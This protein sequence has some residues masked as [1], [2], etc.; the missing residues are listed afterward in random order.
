MD[1]N[2]LEKYCLANSTS[3]DEKEIRSI[4]KDEI[5]AY[6]DDIKTDAM[7]NL[8]VF[9]KGKE[10]AK[11][12]LMLSAHMDEVG[13]IVTHITED[14]FLKFAPVGGI[15]TM[16][17]PGLYVTVGKNN[18][19]GVV[20]LA[21]IHLQKAEEKQTPAQID[22]LCI[23]IGA[24]SKEDAKVAVSEGD[25]IYFKSIFECNSDTVK[26][27]AIDDRM[28]C[29]ILTELI[30]QELPY[31][32]HFC[33]LV[34]E[35][36]G[37]RGAHGAAFTVE[38]DCALVIDVTTAC[39]IPGVPKH[40]QITKLSAGATLPLMDSSMVYD[41]DFLSLAREIANRENMNIQ[42]KEATTGGT[43][44]GSIFLSRG[45]VKTG[46]VVGCARYIHSACSLANIKDMEAVFELTKAMINEICSKKWF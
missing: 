25:F 9:K 29:F 17:L 1:I 28:G 37:T 45:G 33:F 39:D 24:K 26:S 41:R 32:M 46:A 10:R 23:D 6:V 5:T 8:I 2:L 43:D 31:D 11:S 22:D 7:G 13:F 27:K 36:V 3:G 35:E 19:S 12:K 30:K 4:I 18:I 16:I 20:G 15:N 34:Q 21:P 38:P 44:A 42:F 14:G 40:K